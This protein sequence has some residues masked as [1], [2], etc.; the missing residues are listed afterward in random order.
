[1]ETLLKKTQVLCRVASKSVRLMNKAEKAVAFHRKI[2]KLGIVQLT[3]S[4]NQRLVA[5]EKLLNKG[6]RAS[7]QI[8]A[9]SADHLCSASSA[10]ASIPVN[11][12]VFIAQQ[13]LPQNRTGIQLPPAIIDLVLDQFE[14]LHSGERDKKHLCTLALCNKALHRLVLPRIYRTVDFQKN[15]KVLDVAYALELQPR[16][17]NVPQ[18]VEGLHIPWQ[19]RDFPT[20]LQREAQVSYNRAICMLLSACQSITELTLRW[21]Q[22]EEPFGNESSDESNDESSDEFS[23]ESSD[24]SI[25]VQDPATGQGRV[26]TLPQQSDMDALDD[27]LALTP[28]L[29]S[30]S[31]HM[32]KGNFMGDGYSPEDGLG[33]I[34]SSIFGADDV[35]IPEPSDANVFFRKSTTNKL[36]Q[37]RSLSLTDGAT[38]DGWGLSIFSQCLGPALRSLNINIYKWKDELVVRR[39]LQFAEY[40]PHLTEADICW[41]ERNP[42]PKI[43][44]WMK[45]AGASIENLR[46]TLR[47]RQID[48][49][50]LKGMFESVVRN[51]PLIKSLQFGH[52]AGSK[53]STYDRLHVKHACLA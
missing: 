41:N 19:V 1:M 17:Y 21:W 48:T 29:N 39:L 15:D 43:I 4:Q 42:C 45:V 3:P 12:E 2:I 51:A 40:S 14:E 20:G 23:D 26:L 53:A 37:L 22:V 24:E 36:R 32:E 35:S 10:R 34:D 9:F 28:E 47:H 11:P 30:I 38:K 5:S 33:W 13:G 6:E 52:S 8:I 25:N 44:R 7:R 46:L 31:F 49:A 50:S 16:S 18:L 27:F